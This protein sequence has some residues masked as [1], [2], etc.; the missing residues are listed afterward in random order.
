M[1]ILQILQA[2]YQNKVYSFT[3]DI[4]AEIKKM[5]EQSLAGYLYFVYGKPFEQ[6]YLGCT[7]IQEKFYHL[8]SL[9]SEWFSFNKIKH[10]FIKGSVL[11]KLYPDEALRLRGDIDVI[12]CPKDYARAQVLLKEKN[13][14]L[15]D[16]CEHHM[17]Y[18][19][20]HL[21]VELHQSLFERYDAFYTYF[22]DVFEH[23]VQ[24]SSFLYELEPN[25]HYLYCLAHLNK[26]LATG[27]GIRYILDFYYMY[28]K[29]NLNDQFLFTESQKLHLDQLNKSIHGAIYL[30]TSE[31][32]IDDFD[33][34]GGQELID[35]MLKKGVHAKNEGISK[36]TISYQNFLFS[37]Q[38][39]FKYLINT[40]FLINK[41]Q[42]KKI[43][44]KLSRH[45]FLYPI[46]LIHRFFHL[47][48]FRIPSLFKIVFSSKKKVE[49]DRKKQEEIGIKPLSR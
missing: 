12:V 37:N 24:Q 7:L 40:L 22:E 42:R 20:E 13:F 17:E 15:I 3:G 49:K 23:A 30:I 35:S 9:I 47:T 26:H 46:L 1:D 31:S 2:Y 41:D 36:E 18:Q 8:Q 5:N 34:K 29:W 45:W 44:P 6:V 25:Y 10:I 27:E 48:I 28:K 11:S 39:K 14:Q 32:L 16:E 38:S 19:Y 43:Y 33:I 4:S 21:D